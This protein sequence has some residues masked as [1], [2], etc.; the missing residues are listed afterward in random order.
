MK[1]MIASDIH[2]S[3]YYCKKMLDAFDEQKADKLILLGDI[4]YHGP[5]NDLPK[6]YNPKEVIAMLNPLKN[7][8]LCVRGN[9]DTEVDQMV[10]D[11]PVLAEY[12]LLYIDGLTIFATHGHKFNCD[13]LPPLNKGDILLH[14]HT[15]IPVI[16]N[17]GDYTYINPGSVSI[18]KNNSDHSYM[19]LENGEF[20]FHS[21]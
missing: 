19:I 13:K 21:L 16:E 11:F 7:K 4:L 8:L 6:E 3:A 17:K 12:A 14:G 10:L 18:P 5:R 15:H 1:V 9:C 20:S 2:G